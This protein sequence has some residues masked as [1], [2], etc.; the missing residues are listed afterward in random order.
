MSKQIVENMNLLHGMHEGI[1]VLSTTDMSLLLASRPAIRLLKQLPEDSPYATNP[2]KTD[3]T[4]NIFKPFKVSLE[5]ASINL[6][7]CEHEADDNQPSVSLATIVESHLKERKIDS[8]HVYM[9]QRE[10]HS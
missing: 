9:M 3:L 7:R 6:D 5:S 1:V 8:S 2:K 4:R 10:V